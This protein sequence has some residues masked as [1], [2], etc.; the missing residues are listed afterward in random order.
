MLIKSLLFAS[1][2]L[3]SLGSL[4]ALA[5][6][7]P[8]LK[9]ETQQR[10]PYNWLERHE[11]I[12]KAHKSYK[13]QYVVIGDS[14]TH[15]WGGSFEKDEMP[16]VG[17]ESWKALFGSAKASNLGFG[18]DYIDN[19]YYRVEHG[20][21]D[22]ISPKVIIL[23]LGTNNLGHRKDS[24]ETCVANMKAF[25][26]LVR[27]KA[28]KSKILVLGLLPRLETELVQPIKETH[29][30]YQALADGK[31][32]FFANPGKA[33]LEKDS[34]FPE[35]KYMADTVHINAEGYKVLSQALKKELS[36]LR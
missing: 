5:P 33:L 23:L 9:V 21:L 10:D 12:L 1:F 16:V 20:E 15:R 28:P 11:S 32:I 2:L 25:L 3:G 36:T 22:G 6:L 26:E 30:G 13:P 18:F 17:T 29:K 34:D 7:P 14:L 35:K 27:Q 4:F 8:T 24:A 31:H 19:A